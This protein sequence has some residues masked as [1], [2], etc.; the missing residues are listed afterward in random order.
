MKKVMVVDDDIDFLKEIG[1]T[2]D[3]SGYQPFMLS[4][5]ENAAKRAA[6]E[7]PDI[8]FLDLKMNKKSGFKVANELMANP[9]T[10]DIPVI[11][12]TGVFT[13]QEH[14][15][16]MKI[17]NIREYLTKPIDPLDIISRVENIHKK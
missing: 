16:L 3:D 4:A 11:A 2:L 13:R 10:K 9:K 15:L 17:C 8:V 7:M 6:K 1:A 12:I 14:K 5:S